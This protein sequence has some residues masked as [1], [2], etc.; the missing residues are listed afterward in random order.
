MAVSASA[1]D[2]KDLLVKLCGMLGSQ[3]DGERAVAAL[4]VTSLLHQ[5]GWRWEEILHPPRSAPADR[6]PEA[7]VPQRPSEACH[8]FKDSRPGAV[9]SDWRADLAC[10]RRHDAYLRAAERGYVAELLSVLDRGRVVLRLDD[11]TRLAV[12][13]GRVRRQFAAQAWCRLAA[14]A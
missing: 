11:R 12:I 4:K 3:F 2:T 8:D 9:F 14:R 5:A 13:A 7:D 1:E 6:V 10:C